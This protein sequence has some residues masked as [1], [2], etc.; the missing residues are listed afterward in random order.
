VPASTSRVPTCRVQRRLD[1]PWPRALRAVIGG[2]YGRVFQV[3][4]ALSAAEGQTVRKMMMMWAGHCAPLR[5]TWHR[6]TLDTALAARGSERAIHRWPK[7][8][9]RSAGRIRC[10]TLSLRISLPP[11]SPA[12][13]SIILHLLLRLKQHQHHTLATPPLT[14]TV[15]RSH[16]HQSFEPHT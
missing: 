6:H 10:H 5:R 7:Q 12:C 2:W 9:R 3:R 16:T 13:L 11:V 1:S 4:R 15:I 14:T 8:S